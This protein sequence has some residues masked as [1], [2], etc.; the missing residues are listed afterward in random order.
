MGIVELLIKAFAAIGITLSSLILLGIMILLFSSCAST[1]YHKPAKNPHKTIKK[2]KGNINKNTN[3]L[4]YH[5]N[6]SR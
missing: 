5:R 4:F 3:T 1:N 2:W 6:Y